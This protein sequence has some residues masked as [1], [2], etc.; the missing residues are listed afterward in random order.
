MCSGIFIVMAGLYVCKCFIDCIQNKAQGCLHAPI[1]N[2]LIAQTCKFTLKFIYMSF[3]SV[4]LVH[5]TPNKAMLVRDKYLSF[6]HLLWFKIRVS[7]LLFKVVWLNCIQ[8]F[9]CNVYTV[10]SFSYTHYYFCMS[11]QLFLNSECITDKFYQVCWHFTAKKDSL[12]YVI[13]T[14]KQYF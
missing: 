4:F 3:N 12:N 1:W 10:N 8:S 9:Y 7:S 2:H 11:E 6:V 13:E 5:S 14:T